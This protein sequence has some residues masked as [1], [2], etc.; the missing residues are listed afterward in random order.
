M[1]I[2]I[3]NATKRAIAISFLALI[4]QGVFA[5]ADYSFTQ[6]FQLSQLLNPAFTGLQNYTD[7]KIGSRQQWTSFEGAPKSYLLVN[8]PVRFKAQNETVA[9]GEEIVNQPGTQAGIAG[10]LIQKN[11]GGYKDLGA[12]LSFAAHVPVSAQYRLSLGLTTTYS[13]IKAD[14]QE[15]I[16]RDESDQFYQ[17]IKSANGKL[18]YFTIDAGVLLSSKKLVAGYSVLRLASSRLDIN[19]QVNSKDRLS[20]RHRAIFSYNHALNPD[21]EII[22]SVLLAYEKFDGAS[23][24]LNAKARYRSQYWGGVGIDPGNAFSVLAG[25]TWKDNFNFAY[26]YQLNIGEIQSYSA[27]AHEIVIGIAAF[28]KGKHKPW[29]W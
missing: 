26:S 11:I 22:P 2:Q 9:T 18:Q 8:H 19:D 16:V 14:L 13:T 15:F 5:Q 6:Y 12:G 20:T 24:A 3:F 28:N 7:I 1:M 23:V 27:S 10:F 25:F 21:W 29:L 4:T 17:S